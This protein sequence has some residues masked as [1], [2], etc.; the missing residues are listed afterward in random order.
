MHTCRTETT[1]EL[2]E[3]LATIGTFSVATCWRRPDADEVLP[4]HSKVIRPLLSVATAAFVWPSSKQAHP[5]DYPDVILIPERGRYRFDLSRDVLSGYEWFWNASAW[6][7]GSI[8]LRVNKLPMNMAEIFMHCSGPAVFASRYQLAKGDSRSALRYCDACV[9]QG[10]FAFCFSASN[11]IECLSVFAPE[12]TLKELYLTSYDYCRPF[13]RW[14]ECT[15]G[16][17]V[18]LISSGND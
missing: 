12:P 8:V 10:D 9:F 3:N 7:R 5:V 16:E 1:A 11:G 6:C 13:K 4:A 2:L 15:P 17:A 14:F 18:N